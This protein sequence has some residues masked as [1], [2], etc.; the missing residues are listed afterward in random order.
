MA[1]LHEY[2]KLAIVEEMRSKAKADFV[3]EN[4]NYTPRS[5]TKNIYVIFD[6][7]ER[8]TENTLHY[9][10]HSRYTLSAELASFSFPTHER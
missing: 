3:Y 6:E 7:I 5:T 8:R 1:Q 9:D 10:S 2:H 4:T